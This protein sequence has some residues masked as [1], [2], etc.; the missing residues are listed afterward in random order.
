MTAHQRFFYMMLLVI[1]L[2]VSLFAPQTAV[3]S[4]MEQKYI[5][6]VLN[7]MA[8]DWYDTAGN[9]ILW[10]QD[11]FINDCRVLAAYDFAGSSSNGAGRFE[12]LESTGTRNLYLT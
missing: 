6:K 4:K 12:I 1:P 7:L 11:G 2:L 10:I 3:A 8:G 5:T 9:R